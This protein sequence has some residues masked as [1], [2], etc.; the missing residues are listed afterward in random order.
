MSGTTVCKNPKGKIVSGKTLTVN[1]IIGISSYPASKV[2]NGSLAIS[3]TTQEPPAPTWS[4][5]GCPNDSWTAA[6]GDIAFSGETFRL[7]VTQSGAVLLTQD[8]TL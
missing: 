7:T 1:D 4:E 6:F 5:A 2:K 8:I 3:I